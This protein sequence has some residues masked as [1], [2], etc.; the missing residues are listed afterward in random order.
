MNSEEINYQFALPKNYDANNAEFDVFKS[1]KRD[2]KC[3]KAK[4]KL[5]NNIR[6]SNNSI[7]FNYFKIIEESCISPENFKKYSKGYKFFLKFIFPHFNFSKKRF[8][9]IT[10]EWT[11]NYYH[12]HIFA[13]QKLIALQE[14][15][16]VNDALL[17]LPKK[18]LRYSFVLPSLAKFGIKNDRIDFLRRKS[19]I[20]AKS[21]ATATVDQHDPIITRKLREQILT[22]TTKIDLG[23]GERIYISRDGQKLRNVVNEKEVVELLEKYGF[24]KII[25]DKLSYDDQINIC[26]QAKYLISP[27]GAGLTNILFMQ[28]GSN[29]IELATKPN[30]RVKPVSDYYKLCSNLNINYIYHECEMHGNFAQEHEYDFHQAQLFVDIAK[31]EKNLQI[32]FQK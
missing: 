31:L 19:N 6:I 20:K 17:F 5:F 16:L 25:T 18:Y 32:M 10:D 2:A 15:N 21:V 23:F 11:S 13:L 22:H 29:V 8:L 24:K 1:F 30:L 27:H 12:W 9:L 28:E 26:R 14:N 3:S 7:L 4:T